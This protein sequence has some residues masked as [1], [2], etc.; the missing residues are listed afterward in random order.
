MNLMQMRF[1]DFTWRDNPTELNL[2]LERNVRETV[3]PFVGSRT[4]DLGAAKRRVTGEGWFS[5]ED[6]LTQ[7]QALEKVFSQGG[8]G[9]LQLPGQEPFFA[10]MDGLKLLGESG[11]GLIHYSFSFLEY[12]CGEAY[13]GEGEHFAAAGESLWDY[14]HLYSKDIERLRAANPHIR[15]IA[16][17]GANERVVIP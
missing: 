11:E 9:S 4:S 2:A 3:L 5:G 6:C 16:C 13:T 10:V 17:L 1:K 12:R 14:A 7:W 15:D 8:A